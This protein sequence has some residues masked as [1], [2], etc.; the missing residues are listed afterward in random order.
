MVKVF[1]GYKIDIWND[2]V[3]RE[4]FLFL[5]SDPCLIK[6]ANLVISY[7]RVF[8]DHLFVSHILS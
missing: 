7:I 5:D 3:C 6:Q 2:S 4:F 8:Q 1:S